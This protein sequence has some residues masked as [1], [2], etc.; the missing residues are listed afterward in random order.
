MD[1]SLPGS[2]VQGF[3]RHRYWN[4]LPFP[5]PGDLPN[6]GIKPTSPPLAGKFFP[7][8]PPGKHILCIWG[9]K[10]SIS[11]WKGCIKS[12]LVG[13]GERM[14]RNVNRQYQNTSRGDGGC[15]GLRKRELQFMNLRLFLLSWVCYSPKLTSEWEHVCNKTRMWEQIVPRITEFFMGSRRM[16][17]SSRG[18]WQKLFTS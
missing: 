6:P 1:Y 16:H 9:M 12:S 5:P 18:S 15:V 10:G 13:K 2:S 4:G 8:E 14:L 3:P 7:S 17:A 11:V